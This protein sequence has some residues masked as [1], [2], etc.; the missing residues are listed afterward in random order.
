MVLRLAARLLQQHTPIFCLFIINKNRKTCYYMYT[1]NNFKDTICLSIHD[2]GLT[3]T[4][5]I[6]SIL[7]LFFIVF[8]LLLMTDWIIILHE[9]STSIFE[10]VRVSPRDPDSQHGSVTFGGTKSYS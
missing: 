4:T 3:F 2:H 6:V 8:S 7:M 5:N 9:Q 10:Y 1:L